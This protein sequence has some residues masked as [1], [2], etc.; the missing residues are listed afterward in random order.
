MPVTLQSLVEAREKPDGIPPGPYIKM[1]L[2][3]GK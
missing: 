2:R 1:R 3:V